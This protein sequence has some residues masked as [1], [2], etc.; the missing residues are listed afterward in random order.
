MGQMLPMIEVAENEHVLSLHS[1]T[2]AE[3]RSHH[4]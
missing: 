4:R 2:N 1:T 3:W